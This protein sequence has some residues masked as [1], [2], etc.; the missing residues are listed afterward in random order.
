MFSDYK[1][2][3]LLYMLLMGII[4]CDNYVLQEQ[5]EL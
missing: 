3:V 2:L 1:Y 5:C 4:A